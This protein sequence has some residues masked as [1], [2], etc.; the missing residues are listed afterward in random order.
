MAVSYQNYK[1]Q[2]VNGRLRMFGD[3]Y[4]DDAPVATLGDNGIDFNDW[5]NA[6]PDSI[7]QDIALAAGLQFV[8]PMLVPINSD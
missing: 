2:R 4:V 3:V 7:Q 6:Q 5:Y 8:M 1:V